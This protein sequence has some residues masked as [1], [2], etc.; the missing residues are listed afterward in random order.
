[1]KTYSAAIGRLMQK[2]GV[3]PESATAAPRITVS[4]DGRVLIEGHRG[5]LEY[6]GESIS[7]AVAGGMVRVKGEGL[8]LEAMNVRELV[9]TGRIWAVELE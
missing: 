5:L 3:L 1:M 4:G 2:M 9:L 8:M 6:G 7:V